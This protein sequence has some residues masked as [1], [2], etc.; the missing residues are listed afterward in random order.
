[1]FVHYVIIIT[2]FCAILLYNLVRQRV[3]WI[4]H[5]GFPRIFQIYQIIILRLNTINSEF[6]MA[7]VWILLF[8]YKQLMNNILCNL[9]HLFYDGLRH[10]ACNPQET[11]VSSLC[12][13]NRMW[14]W[15]VTTEQFTILIRTR[16]NSA[17]ENQTIEKTVRKTTVT[18]ADW[19]TMYECFLD[20]IL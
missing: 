17:I 2:I 4:F 6:W 16:K 13:S 11:A 1:M 7:V 20:K 5:R 9:D 12:T 8:L 19:V 15:L 14:S 18:I 3:T 10:R